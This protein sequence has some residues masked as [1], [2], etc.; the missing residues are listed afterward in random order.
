MTPQAP[1]SGGTPEPRQRT[2]VG[3]PVPEVVVEA[4]QL[5]KTH[6]SLGRRG[7]LKY[8]G[9]GTVALAAGGAVLSQLSTEDPQALASAMNDLGDGLTMLGTNGG[10]T[11]SWYAQ[12]K[13]T[14]Q[15]WCDIFGI[16]LTWIDGQ[17][18]SNK[19]RASLDS[20]AT[21]PWDLAGI[22]PATAG[23][24]VDPVNKI[25]AGGAGVFEM[26]SNIGGP[27][28][29]VDVLTS[30]TQS[31]YEM[32]Y[33]VAKLLFESVGGTGTVI[34]TR[35]MPGGTDESGRYEGFHAALGEYPGMQLLAEDFARWD[36]SRSQELWQSYLTRFPNISVG[37]FQND[38]MAFGALNAIDNAGRTGIKVGGADGMPDAISAV[39]DGRMLATARHSSCQIHSLPV[40]LGVAWKLGAITTIPERVDVIGPVVTKNNSASV[41]FLQ[42]AGVFYA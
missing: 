16:E 1:P 28:D 8:L 21:R 17:G 32:G 26:T 2:T 30:I 20:A 6:S 40:I 25:A 27:D 15:H 36:R 31:S 11:V 9:V 37:Y 3:T 23:T 13:D 38:D 34:N 24:I 14:M 42:E 33:Q 35:G 5:V 29:T 39:V 41:A 12:G 22:T 4:Q 19:Q 7:L 18:D 10:L